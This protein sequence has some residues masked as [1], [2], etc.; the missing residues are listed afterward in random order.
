MP[1]DSQIDDAILAATEPRWTKVAMV[2]VRA[3]DCF[4][5]DLP[6]GDSGCQIIADRI[7]TLVRDGR[8]DAQGDITQ[9]RNSEVRRAAS[10]R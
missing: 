2:I 3:A 6:D 8:L 10:N 5:T 4:A 1:G 7:S 9:W